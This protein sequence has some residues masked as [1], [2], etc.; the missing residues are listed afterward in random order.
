MS[1]AGHVLDM[2]YRSRY[3][4]TQRK[5]RRNKYKEIKEAY[6]KVVLREHINYKDR[7]T[8]SALEQ[9]EFRRKL[10]KEMSRETR[11]Q[12]LALAISL[13]VLAGIIFM[14]YKFLI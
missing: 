4:E 5:A 12:I 2:I 13:S 3:N 7:K 10:R 11:K 1:S 9:K 14:I 6:E 8:F